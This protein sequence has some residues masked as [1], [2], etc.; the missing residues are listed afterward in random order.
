MLCALYS[1]GADL[2]PE[3]DQMYLSPKLHHNMV[4]M[5]K[6][7]QNKSHSLLNF[8]ICG[9]QIDYLTEPNIYYCYCLH[10]SLISCSLL[11]IASSV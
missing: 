2:L 9:N 6:L 5:F 10:G 7:L 3:Y 8:C 11:E 4:H 1:L